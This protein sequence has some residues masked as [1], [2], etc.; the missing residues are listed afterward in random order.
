MGPFFEK[1][2]L[3]VNCEHSASMQYYFIG[4]ELLGSNAI[5][6][7]R[8]YMQGSDEL[9]DI[10]TKVFHDYGVATYSRPSIGSGGEL[11]PLKGMA[12]GF[13][14]LNDNFYH[15]TLDIP[16]YVPEAGLESVVR[17]Y[18]KI[19]DEVNKVDLAK[20]RTNL[21]TTMGSN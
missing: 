6:A 8:W 16:E 11:G 14:V 7:R 3:I 9:K 19:I 1:T 18:A 12:P 17:A 5:A 2:A 21:V 10:V 4:S 15:T 13:H 20:L